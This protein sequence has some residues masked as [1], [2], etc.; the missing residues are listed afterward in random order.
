MDPHRAQRYEELRASIQ[1]ALTNPR[2]LK[3]LETAMSHFRGVRAAALQEMEGVES[4]RD[5]AHELKIRSVRHLEEHLGLLVAQITRR[6]GVVFRARDAAEAVQYVLT[7]AQ[8]RGVQT[9][10]KSKSMVT[11]EIE[12]NA[13]L[14]KQ[15]F[16]VVETDLGE[17]IIQLAGERPSHI[18]GPAIHK[19]KEEVAEL[20]AKALG[21]DVAPDPS[22]IT[23]H[24]RRSLRS[25][26]LAAE[27]GISG[28]N[29][30]IA[31]TGTLMIVTNEGNARLATS[32]PPIHVAVMGVEKV[33]P[34]FAEA[35]LLL[36][37]LTRSATGQKV[38]SYVTLITGPSVG[39]D[40]EQREFHLVLVD[41]G[42]RR[43]Q[44]DA[45]F[46]EALNCI[47]CG[48]C[49]NVCPTYRVVGGHV[50]GDVY[51]GPIGIPWSIFTRDPLRAEQFAP[52]CISCGLCATVCPVKIPIPELIMHVK[53]I[54]VEAHGQPQV[55]RFIASIGGLSG[56]ASRT[57]PVSNWLLQN[58]WFRGLLERVVG[59][60]RRRPFPQYHRETF[61]AWFRQHRP[62]RRGRVKVA[63]FVDLYADYNDPDLGRAVVRLLGQAGCDVEVP[64]Q[65]QSGMPLLSYGNVT[66]AKKI[67]AY[68]VKLLVDAVRSG[69]FV[70]ASEPTAAYCLKTLYPHFLGTVDAHL[71]GERSFELFEFLRYLERAGLARLSFRSRPGVVGYH[72]P[73]HLKSF[74]P[75]SAS[76]GFLERVGLVVK[77]VDL[78]CCGMAGTFGFK[79]GA[80]GFE[81]SMAVGRPLFDAYRGLGVDLGVTESSV[82]RMQLEYGSGLRFVHPA[83]LLAAS[84]ED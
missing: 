32:L 74:L 52:L 4:L 43:M 83:Q 15:G 31:E 25:K 39:L 45:R 10:V 16:D 72:M 67:M 17:R 3:A 19:S 26:F 80:D 47:K 42:R 58:R 48:A 81:L 84:L 71:V 38:T 79:Q 7:L 65:K 24:A 49:A 62:P 77:A 11:E 69:G 18:V 44:A 13:V 40:G 34:S 57:A 78:G 66:R 9:I 63:Y 70:V 53:Q 23:Q 59:L 73:C 54:D 76:L 61:R 35:A 33:V 37:L 46:V 6:G 56:L 20:F 29:V 1:A 27:M 28:V 5:Q 22:V 14:A 12:L 2:Q 60:D 8:S 82:C 55:N 41:N 21:V 75:Q 51:S 64:R 50:F 36:Q 68:N 30:A